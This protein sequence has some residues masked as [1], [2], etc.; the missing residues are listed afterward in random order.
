MYFGSAYYPEHWPEDRWETDVK[1]M[2]DAGFNVVRLAEFSW[3]KLERFEG[4][5]DFTW[6]DKII[7]MLG[8]NGIS[9]IM[10]TPTAAPPKWL[11]DK[12]SDIYMLDSKGNTRGFGSRRHYCYNNKTYQQYAAQI[13]KKMAEHYQNNLNVIAW[14]IDNEFGN[15]DTTR[16]YCD[17]CRA[18]FAN[19]LKNKYVEI[20]ELNKSW[21]TVFWSQIYN[22]W[23]EI[24]VPRQTSDYLHNPG[25]LLDFMR[26]S[27]DSVVHFQRLQVDILR[28]IVPQHQITHNMMGVFNQIDCYN[29]AQELDIVS[30]DTYPNLNFTKDIEPII[31][32]LNHDVT[33]GVKK[34]NYWV[35]EHQSG[36]PGGNILFR[37][38]KPGELRRWTYQSIAH[39]ADAILYF[40]W[41]TC[42]FGAEEYWHGI[43]GHDGKP[44]RRYEEVKQVS[45]ELSR[46]SGLLN[47][48]TV[49]AKVAI[50]R[51]YDNEWAFEV[52]PHMMEYSCNEHT[53]MYY[54]YFYV[55]NISVDIISPDSDFSNY[56]LIIAPNLIM[57]KDS[58]VGKLYEYVEAG[59]YL[60]M[61]FR[62]GAKEWDNTMVPL[63][64][65]GKYTEL[66]GIEINEYGIIIKS[67]L[68]GL[69][70]VNSCDE[71]NG[72]SW[73][74]V[75]NLKTAEALAFYTAD[76]YKGNPAVSSNSYG[77]GKALYFGTEPDVNCIDV[78]LKSI[79]T[80][81]A[82]EP[83]LVIKTE[84]IEVSRRIG[85]GKEYFFVIN[86]NLSSRRI[87]LDT[88][89]HEL[90]TNKFLEGS[91]NIE[92]NDVMILERQ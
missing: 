40:R 55:N 37:T 42:L 44:N 34:Q 8:E 39:G 16:C 23:S 11:M 6:L 58:M 59:G 83:L 27:S 12:H 17:N 26:F 43:L 57:S 71:Y 48:T 72:S 33:R 68:V 67:E 5:Y 86:H 32:A 30:L 76:Y 91:I 89:Y 47:E 2:R 78:I 69:R 82:I 88:K 92:G 31:T 84:G 13:V 21:G 73:Y 35:T 62:A 87:E 79:C 41:R 18:E 25:T 9:V 1:M 80:E 38:P 3:S 61:D 45:S 20:D 64:L 29:L 65:P 52:Q 90:L 54:R 10:G 46:I 56:S 49:D 19:W 22:N 60:V 66:L 53:K 75:I 15:C 74:D 70:L 50:I 28:E 81:C 14:Q 7:G 4:K 63:T 51:S 36:A 77:K 85:K 24:I